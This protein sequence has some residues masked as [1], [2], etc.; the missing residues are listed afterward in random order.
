MAMRANPA[1]YS[2]TPLAQKLGLK[3]GGTLALVDAPPALVAAIAPLPAAARV[4]TKLPKGA[5]LV[6]L[7]CPTRAALE[8]RL[9][10]VAA[11]LH[12]D[13]ALWIAWPKKS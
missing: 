11:R 3:E 6:L 4:G 13:G 12:P 2:G 9:A 10:D 8:K 7:T 5:P 1:G